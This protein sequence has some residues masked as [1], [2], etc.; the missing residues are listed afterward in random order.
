MSVIV[1]REG[2]APV[3]VA[4]EIKIKVLEE[5]LR[6]DRIARYGKRS[7]TLS[8]LQ[9][10]LLDLE[11]GY[12]A[13]KSKPR[14]RARRLRA[15]EAAGQVSQQQKSRT[16]L[17]LLFAIFSTSYS[18]PAGHLPRLG[19]RRCRLRTSY[20][21]ATEV[22][23]GRHDPVSAWHGK[24]LSYVSFEHALRRFSDKI[25]SETAIVQ[26]RTLYS[27]VAK[28]LNLVNDPAFWGK[29]SI[30]PQSIEDPKT[31]EKLVRQMKKEIAVNHNPKDELINISCTTIS[32]AL[33]SKIV[34]TLVNDYIGYLF[35]M[36]Y[37]ST[38]RV[39]GWLLGLPLR[40]Q[41]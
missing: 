25:A 11:P 26:S 1:Y 18:P 15:G 28:E 23:G 38:K 14:A 40:N 21:S 33:S 13:T 39:S 20:A 16:R 19:I 4:A 12:R 5:R 31:R 3:T 41:K 30:K 9:L 6:L 37:G 7:E 27:E 24:H 29:S 35:E 22:Y 17:K 34:N 2:G 10:A 32:P 8:D 36:R